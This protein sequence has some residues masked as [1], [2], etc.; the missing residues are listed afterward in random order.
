M[1]WLDNLKIFFSL[2]NSVVLESITLIPRWPLCK[3]VKSICIVEV[4]TL[5][6]QQGFN[7]WNFSVGPML[8][9]CQHANNDV[10][11]TTPS[12]PLHNVGPTI[13]CYLGLVLFFNFCTCRLIYIYFAWHSYCMTSGRGEMLVIVRTCSYY[14]YMISLRSVHFSRRGIVCRRIIGIDIP[15]F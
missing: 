10:L 14:F 8:D 15:L 9:Q 3:L 11:P 13:A 12:E 4:P 1:Q 7:C 5:G 6:Q 2:Y